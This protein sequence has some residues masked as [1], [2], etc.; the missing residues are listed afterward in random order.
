MIAQTAVF[1]GTTP[2]RLYQAF[3]SA[4]EH[5]AMTLDG[6]RPAQ[7]CRPNVGEIERPAAGDE[8][9][10]I[11]LTAPDGGSMF[12]VQ[13]TILELVPST[14]IVLGWQNAGWKL[15]LDPRKVSSVPST[16]ILLFKKNV[17]GAE[18]Q[19]VQVGVPD[20]EVRL[21]VVLEELSDIP[22]AQRAAAE[23]APGGEVGPLSTLVNTHWSLVYWEPMKR[24][25]QTPP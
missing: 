6:A 10:A 9:G 17:A 1:F 3:L 16:A 23:G 24:Y 2:E 22:R 21:P 19:L 15:A 14:R 25:F 8:L 7:F 5:Q 20:Y 4:R 12:V 11:G 13:A 18:I